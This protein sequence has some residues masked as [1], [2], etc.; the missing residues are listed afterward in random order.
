MTGLS[1]DERASPFRQ[2]SFSP[3]VIYRAMPSIDTLLAA[4]APWASAERTW[5]VTPFELFMWLD[6]RPR[7]PLVFQ[8]VLRFEGP[9]D[10]AAMRDAFRFA[11][12]RHPP[13]ADPEDPHASWRT[14][15]AATNRSRAGPTHRLVRARSGPGR[16]R[17]LSSLV[18]RAA[19]DRHPQP[20]SG[21]GR[22]PPKPRERQTGTRSA[23]T[24]EK[25]HRRGM[26]GVLAN[27]RRT[28][29]TPNLAAQGQSV[30]RKT[31]AEV[32]LTGLSLIP[33]LGSGRA[34]GRAVLC[35]SRRE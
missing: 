3:G 2:T 14:V 31:V 18:R 11:L 28:A 22:K 30:S 23:Q 9:V 34:I 33:S 15:R 20:L 32:P 19:R 29:D 5:S 35:H 8:V 4:H 12:G 6:D 10:V 27:R 25:H 17:R 24:Q 7:Y 26:R 16:P 21:T 1:F 13:G